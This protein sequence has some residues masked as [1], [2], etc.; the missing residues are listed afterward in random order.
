LISKLARIGSGLALEGI[1]LFTFNQV[2][3]TVEWHRRAKERAGL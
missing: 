3:A 1:H 2:E